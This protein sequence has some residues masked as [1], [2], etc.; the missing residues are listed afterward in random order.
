MFMQWLLTCQYADNFV[1]Y[2]TL[3]N[4]SDKQQQQHRQQ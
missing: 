2:Y 4:K 1:S 3:N